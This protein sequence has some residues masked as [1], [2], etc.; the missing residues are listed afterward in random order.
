MIAFGAE[1]QIESVQIFSILS[2]LRSDKKFKGCSLNYA[3]SKV[4][5]NGR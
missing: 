3:A 4:I 2:N 5:T 1:K